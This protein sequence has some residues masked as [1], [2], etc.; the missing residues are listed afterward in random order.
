MG[1]LECDLNEVMVRKG[2][3]NCRLKFLLVVYP[4]V[5]TREVKVLFNTDW[6]RLEA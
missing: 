1:T 4:V 3:Q 6:L 2:P 5:S